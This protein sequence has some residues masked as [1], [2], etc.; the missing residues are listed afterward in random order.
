MRTRDQ[1]FSY[2]RDK[3]IPKM[4]ATR[5]VASFVRV[6]Y[7]KT[8]ATLTSLVDLGMP[9]TLVVAP[10]RVTEMD[11]WGKEAQAWQHT[12]GIRVRP[13]TGAPDVRREKLEGLRYRPAEIEV[14]SANLF[15][16]L[17][18]QVDLE[19]RYGALVLDELSMWKSP[20]ATRFKRLRTRSMKIQ[21]RFGLTGSPKGNHWLDLWG[22]M[23]AVAAEKPL[24]PTYTS[25]RSRY[26]IEID[27][28]GPRGSEMYTPV[29]GADEMITE[30]IKPWAYSIDPADAPP[31]PA[32]KFNPIEIPIPRAVRDISDELAKELRVRLPG[33]HELLALSS[34]TRASKFRQM[35]GGAVYTL[36]EA[37]EEIH[38]EKLKW[39]GE[40]L[41]ELQGDPVLCFYWYKH[42]KKRI[43]E[44]FPQAREVSKE[45]LDLWNEGK[46]E[47]LLAH[48]MSIGHGLNLQFGGSNIAWYTLPWSGEMLTQ[49]NGR[50]ARPGQKSPTVMAHVP[51]AGAAD[52]AVLEAVSEKVQSEDKLMRDVII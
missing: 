33:G 37:Y 48:P 35:A 7:G 19:A 4:V 16:W 23:F 14:I 18:D 8:A 12:K 11:V 30:R 2:Q 47:L 15:E 46:V 13:L 6:G 52:L 32:V 40:L 41:D 27:T 39:L 20:G 36:G 42:E 3:M 31:L 22:E 28:G 51:L 44:W 17:C 9:R 21:I 5:E 29:Y 1:L 45:S 25:F 34:S 24:G 43:M 10:A 50:L 49:G 38:T 26:F